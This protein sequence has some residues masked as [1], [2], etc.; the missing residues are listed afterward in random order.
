VSERASDRLLSDVSCLTFSFLITKH[1]SHNNTLL[2]VIIMT[3]DNSTAFAPYNIVKR[4]SSDNLTD[5]PMITQRTAKRIKMARQEV[6]SAPPHQTHHCL[7]PNSPP[8]VHSGMPLFSSPAQHQF[9]A[10]PA[11]QE[12]PLFG[13]NYANQSSPFGSTRS[14][15]DTRTTTTPQYSSNK[16][17]QAWT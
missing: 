5:E 10:I 17:H 6:P 8:A 13:W 1:S 15:D 9:R 14:T 2:R 16:N 11:P 7:A 3:F 12:A 4:R